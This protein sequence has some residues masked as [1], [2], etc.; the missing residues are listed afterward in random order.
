MGSRIKKSEDI[1]ALNR[2]LKEKFYQHRLITIKKLLDINSI[3]RADSILIIKCNEKY[4]I[5]IIDLN[6][7]KW[8]PFLKE[9]V[10]ILCH[11]KNKL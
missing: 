6:N 4:Y 10:R 2:I 5:Y 3:Y 8:A 7:K 9:M 1:N 11:F